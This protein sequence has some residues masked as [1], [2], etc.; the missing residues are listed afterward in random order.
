MDLNNTCRQ[1]EALAQET[2]GFVKNEFLH[3]DKDKI[4]YKGKNDL[5]SYVDT[6][7]EKMLVQG[8]KTIIPEAGFITEE[9]TEQA[10]E[11]R[12]QWVIDPLDGTTNFAHG[13]P[14]FCISIALLDNQ[15]PVLGI[16]WELMSDECYRAVKGGGAFCNDRPLKVSDTGSLSDALLATGFPVL[17]FSG[18]E[19]YSLIMQ[20][21]MQVSHGLRRFGAAA[22]DLVWVARGRYEGFFEYNLKP[23]DVAAGALIVQEAGGTVSNFAGKADYL[24]QKQIIA[25]GPVY[26]ELQQVIAKHWF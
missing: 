18:L 14:V 11:A 25:S 19:A 24:F 1:V 8:L 6:G 5:V 22:I 7:S 3:F 23:Y 15:E 16:V 20:E 21:L 9:G 26:H 10:R 13:L 12:Y 17:D 4:E 2:A